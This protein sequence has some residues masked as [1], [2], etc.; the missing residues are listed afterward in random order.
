MALAGAS[1]FAQDNP[2]TFGGSFEYA[3]AIDNDEFSYR[4]DND[5]VISL[6]AQIGE[7]T[8]F[9]VGFEADDDD[10]TAGSNNRD[11]FATDMSLT[12]D[13]TGALGIDSPVGVSLRLGR[14]TLEPADNH[15]VAGYEDIEAF[16]ITE[17]M[18]GIGLMLDVMDFVNVDLVLYPSTYLNYPTKGNSIEIGAQA[19]GS[20]MEG[21]M[22]YVAYFVASNT[23]VK[24]ITTQYLYNG[25]TYDTQADAFD[26]FINAGGDPADWATTVSG[27]AGFEVETAGTGGGQWLGANFGYDDETLALGFMW[28][29]D[30]LGILGTSSN[31]FVDEAGNSRQGKTRFGL[32]GS[33]RLDLGDGMALDPGLA[34]GMM[35]GHGETFISY[36]DADNYIESQVGMT[37]GMSVGV[38]L[39]FQVNERL[40]FNTAAA[41]RSLAFKTAD[42]KVVTAGTATTIEGTDKDIEDILGYEVGAQYWL[43]GVRYRLGWVGAAGSRQRA[44]YDSSMEGIGHGYFRVYASF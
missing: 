13:V 44:Y 4:L 9:T 18:V 37:E 35:I 2:G 14:Q 32:S 16:A 34:L 30:F 33:Y 27:V 6:E 29:T 19:Y 22:N 31:Y 42:V 8:T 41:L 7:F 39:V 26:A 1:V 17:S 10:G 25:M 43:D 36:T 11:V 15:N 23:A 5:S 28:E 21:Q 24:D 3:M 38:N 20:L 12:Q 40:S